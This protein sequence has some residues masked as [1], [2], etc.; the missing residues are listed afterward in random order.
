MKNVTLPIA[1]L[2]LASLSVSNACQTVPA[3]SS[4]PDPAPVQE[5]VPKTPERVLRQD[6]TPLVFGA[7]IKL[8][9][10]ENL[11]NWTAHFVNG[12]TNPSAAFRVED[13]I[14][15]CAGQPI[16]YIR[17][18]VP[19]ESFR[20]V[21]EWR[22]DPEVGGGNS[23]ILMRLHGEDTVWPN[24][25]E[26]QLNSR[27]AGDI[28]NIGDFPM[29]TDPKRVSGRRTRKMAPTNEKPLG[30]WNRY[31]ILL[32]GEHLELKVNGLVQNTATGC[33]KIK[34]FIGL[35][36]EGVAIEFRTV[37]LQPIINRD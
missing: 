8:F 13:G 5:V 28:W 9:N 24:S 27:D 22:F 1:C 30:E 12:S 7:P 15:K 23:G 21:V 34:G 37:E 26:A 6:G 3:D 35:Q 2:L 20:L 18:K 11:S 36:S 32:D 4:G 14:L 17:T 16:G 29:K 19:Y 31:E 10:G 25:I 33:S